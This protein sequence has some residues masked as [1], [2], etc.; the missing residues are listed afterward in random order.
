MRHELVRL[1]SQLSRWLNSTWVS[2]A[3]FSR[4]MLTTNSLTDWPLTVEIYPLKQF[5][6]TSERTPC[7][8]VLFLSSTQRWLAYSVAAE[9]S[10]S[11]SCV[12]SFLGSGM[13]M[14]SLPLKYA[15]LLCPFRSNGR[16]IIR[17]SNATLQYDPLVS[18]ARVLP[19]PNFVDHT[20]FPRIS[21]SLHFRQCLFFFLQ[22]LI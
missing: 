9:F 2:W 1:C 8:R 18:P 11:V 17:L 4:W 15:L 21:W 20:V 5:L 3:D 6:R 7:P 12:G 19:G 13:L 14:C 16:H 22:I 10:S